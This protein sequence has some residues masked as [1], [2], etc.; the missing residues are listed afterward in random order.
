MIGVIVFSSH[1]PA[2]VVSG[3]AVVNKPVAASKEPPYFLLEPPRKSSREIIGGT[4]SAA[5]AVVR[6]TDSVLRQLADAV[7][8]GNNQ[9]PAAY[10]E[11]TSPQSPE[12][13]VASLEAQEMPPFYRKGGGPPPTIG[14]KSAAIAD[15]ETGS[16]LWSL[17]PDMRWPLASITKLMSAVVVSRNMPLN[18]STTMAIADFPDDSSNDMKPGDNFTIGDLRSA[19][20]VESNN[21]AA[22]AIANFYGYGNFVAAMNAKA[23][24]WGLGDT[25]YDGPIGLSAANQS[26]ANNLV[27]LAKHIYAQ[28]PEVFQLTKTKSVDIAELNSGRKIAVNNINF[29]AGEDDFLGGKTG[30]TDE[31]HGNLLSLFSYKKRPILV[32]VLG[33]DDRFGDTTKLLSWF[34]DNFVPAAQ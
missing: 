15:I 24:E 33:T 11:K 13:A 29:F 14:V 7:G 17:N 18:Q 10:T 27:G 3:L 32:I 8:R 34:E 23:K 9:A 19:M 5:E 30:Y 28:Y 4:S 20:L 25:Y 26:T 12:A 21:E 6:K 2:P 22:N 16:I 1:G 31:A